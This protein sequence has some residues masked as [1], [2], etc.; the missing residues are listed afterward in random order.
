MIIEQ[1]G[2]VSF[3]HLRRRY[4]WQKLETKGERGKME[5]LISSFYIVVSLGIVSKVDGITIG[6]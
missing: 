6:H 4:I 5:M 1:K 2:N 3:D